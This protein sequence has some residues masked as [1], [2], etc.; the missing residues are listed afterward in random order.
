VVHAV[1]KMLCKHEDL[2]SNSSPTE[3]I[4]NI[5]ILSTQETEMRRKEVPCQPG[6]KGKH[7]SS[8]PTAHTNK[9]GMEECFEW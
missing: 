6:Q 8:L 1:E 3:N 9:K 2:S 4:I 7:N 5:L